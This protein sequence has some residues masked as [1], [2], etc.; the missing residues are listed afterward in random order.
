[1]KNIIKLSALFCAA[2]LTAV[3]CQKD[4]LDTAQYSDTEVTLASFGPNPAMRGGTVTF[5]GSN[6]DKVAAVEIPG[7]GQI[8][9]SAIEVVEKGKNS[10]IRVSLDIESP[11]VGY[12]ILKTSD[13]KELK[14]KSELTYKEPI[15]FEGFVANSVNYPGDVITLNGTYMD[16]VKAVVFA[17]GEEVEVNEG[18]TRHS[19]T[20]TIPANALTGTIILSDKAEIESLFYSSEELVIGEPTVNAAEKATVKVGETISF[21]GEHLDMIEK[22]AMDGTEVTEFTL[23]DDH[24]SISFTLP[25]TAKSGD[26]HAVSFAGKSYKAGEVDAIVPTVTS[27]GPSPVKAGK[28]LIIKGENLD[29]IT[30]VAF[31]GV[32]SA[33]FTYSADSLS[34][35]VSTKVKE[36]KV[37]L[38]TANESV[39]EAEFTLVHPTVTK[40]DPESIYAGDS[41]IVVGTDLDLIVNAAL[42]K[43]N[44]SICYQ[45]ADTLIIATAATAASGKLILSLDNEET[46]AAAENINVGYHSLVIVTE[47]PASQHIGELVT[48]K[49]KNMSLVESI[50]IGDGKVTKYSLRTDEELSFLMPY[51]K[52]GSYP[53]KFVLYDG[54]EEI[55]PEN[56]EVLLERTF[57]E[58]FEGEATVSW[59]NAV[60]IPNSKLAAGQKMVIEYKVV[61]MSENYSML[62]TISN[63]WGFNPEGNATYNKNFS[64]DGVWEVPVTK[65]L[66]NNLAGKDMSL[67]GYGCAV[68]KVTLIGEIA[69]EKT[70]FEG[71]CDMSWGDTG[72]FGVA[73]ESFDGVVAG[74]KL[75]F[76][77]THTHDWGQIQINNGWW[78]QDGIVFPEVGGAYIKT[79]LIE[80]GAE[81]VELTLTEETLASIREKAGDY[82]GLNDKHASPSG[83]YGL[84]IQGQDFRIEKVTIL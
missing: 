16:L 80:A 9:G 12:V 2:V 34:I 15:V 84:V 29:L 63:D 32:E 66:M 24:K 28:T 53:I 40:V 4:E 46:V 18:S 26:F 56:I 6:L 71:P 57:D 39:I 50:Y 68:L 1:M 17:G 73:L 72:R 35:S 38:I 7:Q 54:S 42:G 83:K 51:N 59:N 25:A 48:L 82:K 43:N 33:V 67:T 36:G 58:V 52:I 62:R 77:L 23:A 60:T 21:T 44:E 69:Q 13:G 30:K 49:G 3:S 55:Q 64:E 47:R 27:V 61:P 41:I 74:Q 10:Q 75:I 22:I 8:A 14:T 65:E 37:Q 78:N 76:Y 81:R 5:Y 45:S 79:D 20:V 70:V 11:E 19:A 31:D